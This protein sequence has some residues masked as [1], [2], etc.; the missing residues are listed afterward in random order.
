MR[1]YN[2][3]LSSCDLFY[4]HLNHHYPH[5]LCYIRIIFHLC[6]LF[7][8]EL[9]VRS[10]ILKES[11]HRGCLAIDVIGTDGK[12]KEQH[13]SIW[14]AKFWLGQC[15]LLGH[16]FISLLKLICH[17]HR[18]WFCSW[19]KPSKFNLTDKLSWSHQRH[20]FLSL[21]HLHQ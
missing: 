20:T 3:K 15:C 14:L 12:L 11:H 13:K 21:N 2:R 18:N 16:Q 19:Y 1:T 10:N 17:S 8:M 6:T 5:S 9:L 7:L 4:L